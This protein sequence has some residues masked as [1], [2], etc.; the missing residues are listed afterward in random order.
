MTDPRRAIVEAMIGLDECA[1][2]DQRC[3]RCDV[4]YPTRRLNGELLCETC[5]EADTEEGD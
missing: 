4:H 3:E 1:A 5:H 2:Q